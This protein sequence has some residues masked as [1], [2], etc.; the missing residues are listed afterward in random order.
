MSDFEA[1]DLWSKRDQIGTELLK[2]MKKRMWASCG[3]TVTDLG[4]TN[5][6]VPDL[7]EKSIM[8]TNIME[9]KKSRMI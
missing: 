3:I 9:Q 8:E 4:V 2:E 6:N 7:V 1:E 5:I